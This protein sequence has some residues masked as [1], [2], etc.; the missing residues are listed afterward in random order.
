MKD[1]KVAMKSE[2]T[3]TIAK[4]ESWKM[5][6]VIS[7]RYDLVNYLFT[8]GQDAIWRRRLT[9]YLSHAS[10]Q[11]ILDVA[12]GT[13]DVAIA[14]AQE[15]GPEIHMIYGV[16]MAEQML[17][18]ARSKIE[19][20]NLTNMIMLQQQDA[21]ALTFMDQTFDVVVI[22]FGIR[23][24]PDL[25]LALLEMY[26]VLKKGGRILILET[27]L[28]DNFFLRLGHLFYIRFIIPCIG[29][30]F[31]GNWRAYKYLNQTIEQF[32]YGERFCKIL[33]QMGFKNIEA[34]PLMGGVATIY[35]GER[36]D[37]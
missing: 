21:Q 17:Q 22:A 35:V 30:I 3:L 15:H 2:Q 20:K 9:Q 27:S 7:A 26:R 29:W 25:R 12:T 1:K 11:I 5:F 33:K 16:D 24:I 8:F 6:N 19:K 37:I 14:L 23:N 36:K 32:P 13:G 28:P 10:G 18:M 31:A 34:C 4:T